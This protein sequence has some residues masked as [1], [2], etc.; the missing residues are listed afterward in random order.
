MSNITDYEAARLANIKK[1]EELLKS[2]GL[3]GASTIFDSVKDKP[4]PKPRV[5]APT[6]AKRKV[7]ANYPENEEGEGGSPVVGSSRRAS[8]RRSTGTAAPNYNLKELSRPKSNRT[9]KAEASS[10]TPSSSS[11]PAGRQRTLSKQALAREEK[12]SRPRP[13]GTRTSARLSDLSPRKRQRTYAELSDSDDSG[14]DDENASRPGGGGLWNGRGGLAKVEGP[15]L[16]PSEDVDGTGPFEEYE[17]QPLPRLEGSG[18]NGSSRIIFEDRWNVFTP[19]LTPEEM[20]RGGMFG[21][22]AFRRHYSTVTKSWLEPTEELAALPP[23]WLQN[24]DTA[25]LLT[26][27]EYDPA[28]NR[29]GVKASQSLAEWEKASWVRVWDPRGWWGWYIAFFQ[30]R[31][32]SDDARQISRWLKAV[33][34]AGRFKRGL[35]KEVANSRGQRYDDDSIAPVLRQTC[36]HWAVQL[37]REDYEAAVGADR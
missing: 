28:L 17:R 19:N 34:P 5:S 30:G 36:W 10:P 23:H 31:R 26:R 3:A 32:C 13:E 6:P 15:R 2:L 4:K 12:F 25:A 27:E 29:F 11:A 7:D 9:I 21:G 37:T 16:D 8:S 33:G 22:T 14:A 24:L 1:N 18:T 35:I 20:M